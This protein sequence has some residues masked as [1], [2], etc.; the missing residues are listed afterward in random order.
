MSSSMSSSMTPSV[1]PQVTLGSG[2]R[3]SADY[4][5]YDDEIASF[6]RNSNTSN[7]PV[8]NIKTKFEPLNHRTVFDDSRRLLMPHCPCISYQIKFTK[9]VSL[10]E[11]SDFKK[12]HFLGKRF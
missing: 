2:S 12:V 7:T 11:K 3:L 10:R 9:S 8:P 5:T 6:T 4:T 1:S